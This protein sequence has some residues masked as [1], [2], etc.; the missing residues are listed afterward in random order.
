MEKVL[1]SACLLGE[2]VRYNAERFEDIPPILR[3]W[4]EEGRLVAICPEVDGGLPV[5]RPPAE[6]VSGDGKEVLQ[7]RT[8]LLTND[9]NDVTDYFLKGAHIA[10]ETAQKHNIRMAILKERSPSCG[11][12]AIYD[13]TF[14]GNI[15]PGKGVT[16]ALL[17]THGVRV[18]S[19]ETL[20]EAEV[21]LKKLEQGKV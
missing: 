13:G 15:K 9:G 2:L 4:Q 7:G 20:E 19:E 18:F 6:I 10:L 14:T 1:I 17:E 5:P 11:S 12:T 8:R 3:K 16:V 21:Y